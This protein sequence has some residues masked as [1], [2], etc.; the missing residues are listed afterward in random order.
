M[1]GMHLILRAAAGICTPL[2]ALFAFSVLATRP[3]GAGV[4]LSAGL[5]MGMV[6]VLHVLVFGAA[7]ARAAFPPLLARVLL[8]L[9]LLL[10][11]VA[12][13]APLLPF[14]AEL[15]EAGLFLAVTAGLALLL[16]VLI[17]RAPTLRDEEW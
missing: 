16:G 4:G 2:I 14:G 10:T 7:A 6:L 3:A 13:S 15:S 5:A 12:T 1:K 11:L 9:G 8:A 17:S